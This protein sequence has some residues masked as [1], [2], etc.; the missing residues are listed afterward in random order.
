MIVPPHWVV[1]SFQFLTQHVVY[2]RHLIKLVAP[3]LLFVTA[4]SPIV[5]GGK[6]GKGG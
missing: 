4:A 1:V 2:S 5:V 6:A 3:L